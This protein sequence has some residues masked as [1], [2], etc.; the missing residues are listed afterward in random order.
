MFA[1]TQL[2]GVKSPLGD[3]LSLTGFTAQEGLSQLFSLEL[4]LVATNAAPDV[5]RALLGQQ[6]FVNAGP[7]HFDGI[8]SRVTQGATSA[9]FTAYRAEVV[10]WL[11]L[12]TQNRNTRSF[13]N[14]SVP[15]LVESVVAEHGRELSLRLEGQYERRVYAVQHNESDYDFLLRLMEEEGIY[16][17]FEQGSDGHRLVLV[18]GAA[19]HPA[20]APVRL[21]PDGRLKRSRES[22]YAWE[23]SQEVRAGKLTLWDHHFELPGNHLEGSALLQESVTAGG[24]EHVL[25]TPA[26]DGLEIY[27]YPGGYAERFDGIDPGGGEQPGEL[28]K[29][30]PAASR[31]AELRMQAEAASALE[32]AGASSVR[33]LAAGHVLELSG[34]GDRFDGKYLVTGVKH[35]FER[36]GDRVAYGNTFTCIPDALPFR[37]PRTAPRP[38]VGPQTAVVVGPAG[39]ELFTDKYGRIKVRFHWDRDEESSNWVRV[40]HP[41]GSGSFSL[42]EVGDEVLVAFESGDPDRPIVLGSLWNASDPPP[43]EER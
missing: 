32:I 23:K 16:Y 12:L 17:F 21:D 30:F 24:V 20:L 33:A 35:T 1:N 34:S 31:A 3:A 8:C 38:S 28:Q 29:L 15:E 27:D 2:M 42:P 40:A 26:G 9:G 4:D 39:E 37:L 18:D 25:R 11:W 5:Y 10:P 13:Q 43:Q 41:S 36:R 22:V 19:G 6:L 7:R 14:L